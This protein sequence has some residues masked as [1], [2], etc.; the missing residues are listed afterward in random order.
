MSLLFRYFFIF[1]MAMVVSTIEGKFKYA[2]AKGHGGGGGH[3]GGP[4]GGAR[5]WARWWRK[6]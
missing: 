3:G 6:F 1:L 4:G 2:N 5:W